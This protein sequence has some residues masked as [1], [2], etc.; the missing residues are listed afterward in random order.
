MAVVLADVLLSRKK[1]QGE[2]TLRAKKHPTLFC[3]FNFE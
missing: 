3:R 1:Y 2:F